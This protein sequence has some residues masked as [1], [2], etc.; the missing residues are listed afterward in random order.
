MV[1]CAKWL[2]VIGYA[3]LY[4]VSEGGEVRSVE[5]VCHYKWRGQPKKRVFPSTLLRAAI[6][7]NGYKL[8]TLSKGNVK[9]SFMVHRLVCE[10]FHG[11]R[12]HPKMDVAHA[13]GD[14]MNNAASNLRWASR[15]ENMEDTR[16]NGRL[17]IGSRNGTA[18]LN[19]GLV[20]TIRGRLAKGERSSSLAS[21]FGVGVRTISSI[22]TG[23]SWSHV[24]SAGALAA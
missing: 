19:E 8:V 4:E 20:A 12:P 10:A 11:V 15:K 14:R 17:A 6:S 22:R 5:R 9:K 18:K 13:D 24:V 7:S 1:N 21:E 2:P 23:Q 3:G 16:R